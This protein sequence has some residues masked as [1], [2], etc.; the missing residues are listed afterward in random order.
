MKYCFQK[1]QS[2][3][4][5]TCTPYSYMAKLARSGLSLSEHEGRSAAHRSKK[6]WHITFTK[7]NRKTINVET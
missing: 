3:S 1:K 7:L 2:R 6:R 4:I 5:T